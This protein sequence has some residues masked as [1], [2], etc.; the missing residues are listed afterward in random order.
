MS[1]CIDTPVD[2]SRVDAIVKS[3]VPYKLT[4]LIEQAKKLA[5]GRMSSEEKSDA[6]V[7]LAEK[8][9]ETLT[10]FTPCT[11]GCSHCCYMAVAVSDFEANMIGRYLGRD[12]VASA[13]KTLAEYS[14]PVVSEANLRQYTGVPCSLLGADGKCTVYP[15][16]P[17][18]CRTHH[19][20][21]KDETNCII[22]TDPE[23]GLPTTPEIDIS[24]FKILHMMV[25]FEAGHKF[26]DIRQWFP[27]NKE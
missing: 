23:E 17:I 16:R 5:L 3:D 12:K 13:A 24:G 21:A 8:V 4:V 27:A 7:T 1:K 20:L 15:V 11:K 26:A 2:Q 6:M 22:T 9:S 10:P 19:N 14:D 18:A 25:S